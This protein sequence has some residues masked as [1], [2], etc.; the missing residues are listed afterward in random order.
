MAPIFAKLKTAVEAVGR[1][2][3][4]S[5][6]QDNNPQLTLYY[7]APTE[8]ITPKVKAKLGIK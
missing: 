2:G 7:G 3:G 1:E 5:L 4:F 8:D 6:I